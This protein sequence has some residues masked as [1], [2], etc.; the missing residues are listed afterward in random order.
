MDVGRQ[1]GLKETTAIQA[2]TD[3]TF[4]SS[5]PP[6]VAAPSHESLFSRI[7]GGEQKNLYLW[8]QRPPPCPAP[9]VPHMHEEEALSRITAVPKKKP[10]TWR[11]RKAE[12]VSICM[13]SV[14]AFSSVRPLGK[15]AVAPILLFLCQVP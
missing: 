12:L 1:A 3:D 7:C 13:M 6:T 8:R 2:I 5:P 9:L 15:T 4:P 11:K 10:S 14:F